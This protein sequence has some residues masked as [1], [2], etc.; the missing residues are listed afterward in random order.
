MGLISGLLTL[1]LAPVRGVL[2]VAELVYE[3][4]Q[5]E[6]QDPS[7][8]RAELAEVERARAAEEI[9]QDEA[10]RREDELMEALWQGRTPGGGLEV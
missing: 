2:W 5:R 3:E 4:A 7:R 8:L 10:D 9:T 1:P 6:V